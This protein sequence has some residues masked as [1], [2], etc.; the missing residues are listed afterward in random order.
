MGVTGT[1]TAVAVSAVAPAVLEA[2][3]AQVI[4]GGFTA[5]VGS[6]SGVGVAAFGGVTVGVDTGSLGFSG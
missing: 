4:E 3:D 1:A 2:T 6:F 5:A